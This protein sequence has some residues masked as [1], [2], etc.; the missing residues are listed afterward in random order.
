MFTELQLKQGSAILGNLHLV[1]VDQ[2]W[3]FCKFTPTADFREFEELFHRE[4]TLLNTGF[5]N[6]SQEEEWDAVVD[7]I[8]TLNLTLEDKNDK[9]TI[10]DFLLHIDGS[11][12]WFRY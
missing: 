6:K 1:K 5:V 9:T 2:P 11:E 3:F 12:A 8:D 10:K 4:V 7:T